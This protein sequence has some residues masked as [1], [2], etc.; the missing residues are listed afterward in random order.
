MKLKQKKQ[1]KEVKVEKE[2]KEDEKPKVKGDYKKYQK[3]MLSKYGIKSPFSIKDKAE[4][5]KFF[6]DLKK[7]IENEEIKDLIQI[8]GLEVGKKYKDTSELRYGK[9]VIFSDADSDGSHI[10][11]LIL[12]IFKVY[13]KELLELNYIEEFVSPTI[14]AS[15][16]KI[17]KMFYKLKDYDKWV[18]V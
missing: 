3:K 15:K 13:W 14:I 12:N 18:S 8:L 9:V 2:V 6:A 17:K 7:V 1:K 16:G 10:K 11:G 5:K 4:R